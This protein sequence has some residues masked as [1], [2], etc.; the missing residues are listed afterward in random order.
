[1][2]GH[3]R[4]SIRPLEKKPGKRI[5]FRHLDLETQRGSSPGV[6]GAAE[7]TQQL[8]EG[9]TLRAGDETAERPAS[10]VRRHRSGGKA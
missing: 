6:R 8:P 10:R 9:A 5:Q 3:S 7:G 4:V 2:S 1:M